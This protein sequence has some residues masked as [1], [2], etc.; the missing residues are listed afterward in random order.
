MRV[1]CSSTPTGKRGSC[2]LDGTHLFLTGYCFLPPRT[3]FHKVR[4]YRSLGKQ[5]LRGLGTSEGRPPALAGKSSRLQSVKLSQNFPVIVS[6]V[7]FFDLLTFRFLFGISPRN[8]PRPET[9]LSSSQAGGR[10]QVLETIGIHRILTFGPEHHSILTKEEHTPLG[11]IPE[12]FGP[13]DQS[14][15]DNG[16][17]EL[18]I[19]YQVWLSLFFRGI[20]QK[21]SLWG[22]PEL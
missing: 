13:V 9:W 8:L 10:R 17:G 19:G 2:P 3:A 4:T 15:V 6:V 18:V 5:T 21:A 7:S 1:R 12:R 20:K 16:N 14:K 22:F 11:S